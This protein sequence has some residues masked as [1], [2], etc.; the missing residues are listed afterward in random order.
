MKKRSKE[1]YIKQ[2]CYLKKEKL[3][4]SVF[5]TVL[6]HEQGFELNLSNTI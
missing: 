4:S 2:R 5:N 1:N 3:D 6:R